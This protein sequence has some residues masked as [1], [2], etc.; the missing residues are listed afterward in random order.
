MVSPMTTRE[1]ILDRLRA[2]KYPGFSRGDGREV[3]Q[4]LGVPFLGEIPL[5]PAIRKGGDTG[6]PIV[7]ADPESPQ[8]GAF[9]DL[10]ARIRRAAE[11]AAEQVP[12]L[13]VR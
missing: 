2:V 6:A 1:A 8:A 7:V 13:I 9:C 11:D 3:S 10:A 5:D 12:T 4:A